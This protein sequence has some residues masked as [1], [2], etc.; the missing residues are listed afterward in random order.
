[1]RRCTQFLLPKKLVLIKLPLHKYSFCFEEIFTMNRHKNC[2][3]SLLT[4]KKTLL[5]NNNV[6]KPLSKDGE[7]K[8]A[9]R[10]EIVENKLLER[11]EN[12]E[13]QLEATNITVEEVKEDLKNTTVLLNNAND[14]I[15]GL[16]IEINKMKAERAQLV[17]AAKFKNDKHCEPEC[18]HKN[19]NVRV[20]K[21]DD[22]DN[23]AARIAGSHSAK[24]END[25]T[26][27][28][29][30]HNAYV[31]LPYDSIDELKV[32]KEDLLNAEIYN[33]LVSVI[34]SHSSRCQQI[35]NYFL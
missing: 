14:E 20:K 1:M 17:E 12:V 19:Q 7:K 22:T 9:D 3:S 26:R 15:K 8:P 21:S 23:S 6:A 5:I 32:F 4:R 33:H 30:L 29:V 25:A 34:V 35:Y 28:A 13:K 18:E 10:L 2:S 31:K 27:I 24:T 11:L 16:T